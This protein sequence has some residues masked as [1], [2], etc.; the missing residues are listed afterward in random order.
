VVDTARIHLLEQSGDR[1]GTDLDAEG[2]EFGGDLGRSPA[3]HFRP[4]IGSPAVSCF[5]IASILWITSGV[6]SMDRGRP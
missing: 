6:F 4:L 3:V 5:M 1:S 2:L